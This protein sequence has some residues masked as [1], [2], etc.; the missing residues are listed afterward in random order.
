MPPP[1]GR[2][3]NKIFYANKTAKIS[4]PGEVSQTLYRLSNKRRVPWCFFRRQLLG[5]SKQCRRE[6]GR[7]YEAEEHTRTHQLVAH[8]L[9]SLVVTPLTQWR[10]HAL[11]LPAI[12]TSHPPLSLTAFS[13]S[14][15]T[16][17][18][19]YRLGSQEISGWK[20]LGNCWMTFYR[21]DALSNS[22]VLSEWVGFNVPINTL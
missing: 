12:C 9:T 8:I 11:Q 15:V 20:T 6:N 22:H 2:G 4:L 13:N 18:P 5:E 3:H 10:K 14:D 17:L 1:M 16:F 19:S 7:T 21:P